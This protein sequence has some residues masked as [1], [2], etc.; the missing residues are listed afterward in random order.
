MRVSCKVLTCSE[1]L[2]CKM[3]KRKE[4]NEYEDILYYY[5][6]RSDCYIEMEDY[7]NAL[8]DLDK[9]VIFFTITEISPT[10]V[11]NIEPSIPN[12]SPISSNFLKT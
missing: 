12:I 8:R 10:L 2:C 5:D 1:R 7:T 4:E 6:Y 9:M 11:L 3:E